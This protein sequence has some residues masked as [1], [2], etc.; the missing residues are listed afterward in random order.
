MWPLAASTWDR[1]LPGVS[2]GSHL[3]HTTCNFPSRHVP[4]RPQLPHTPSSLQWKKLD[5]FPIRWGNWLSS[6]CTPSPAQ[7]KDTGSGLLENP[8]A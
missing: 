7:L 1:L 6:C 2:T 8:L 4:V 5:P 3:T